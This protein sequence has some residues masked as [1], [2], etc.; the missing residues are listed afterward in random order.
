MR[1]HTYACNNSAGDRAERTMLNKIIHALE[2]CGKDEDIWLIANIE[3]APTQIDL[4]LIKNDCLF[5]VD[6]KSIIGHIKGDENIEKWY[7]ESADRTRSNLYKNYFKQAKTQRWSLRNKIV[8]SYKMGFLRKFKSE[9]VKFYNIQA[10]LCVENGSSW[11]INQVSPDTQRWFNVVTPNTICTEIIQQKSS[12][13]YRLNEREINEIIKIFHAKPYD[14]DRY[15]RYEINKAWKSIENDV[16]SFD[17]DKNIFKKSRKTFREAIENVGKDGYHHISN[18]G[19]ALTYKHFSKSVNLLLDLHER[20][21][22]EYDGYKNNNIIEDIFRN[23]Y[24]S[25]SSHSK[26]ILRKLEHIIQNLIEKEDVDILFNIYNDN[27]PGQNL[28][29]HSI[30]IEFLLSTPLKKKISIWTCEY[31]NLTV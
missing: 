2:E 23:F 7:V 15:Y 6:M 26:E 17:A 24:R 14:L 30:I 19:I 3:L 5:S 11:D 16:Y 9:S 8:S 10:W 4:L 31:V 20:V 28:P 25:S 21:G 27:D 13:E 1:V 22:D 29:F 12:G 18:H